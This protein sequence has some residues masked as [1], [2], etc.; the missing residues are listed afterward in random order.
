MKKILV[1]GA[2]ALALSGCA[3]QQPEAPFTLT[4][5]HINDTHSH[6]DP[7]DVPLTLD[8]RRVYTRLG[9][10][11]RL[12]SQA[13]S[14]REQATLADQPLLFVHGGGA[15]QGSGYFQLNQGAMNA[16]LLGRL[17]L[18]AM[19][20]GDPEFALDN[21]RLAVFIDSVGVPVLAA[22]LNTEREPV[23]QGA[24]NLYPYVLYAFDGNDKER[25]AS[26]EDAGRDPV[27]AVFGLVPEALGEL[28]ANTGGLRFEHEVETAQ[29][30]VDALR[31]Q[32]VKHIVA[33][34]HLGLERDQR[35]ASRV[36]G[37]DLIVG[38]RSESLLG[39]FAS[40]GL[41]KQPPY[42]Q[43]VT[44]PDGRAKTCV[45]QA[46]HFGQAM[47]RVSVTFSRDGRVTRCEGGNTLLAD[48]EFYRDV[49]RADSHRLSAAEQQRLNEVVA[50]DPRITVV[51]EDAELRRH[52]DEQYQPALNAAYGTV[53]GHV[54]ATLS[55][56]L[57]ERDGSQSELAPL[58]AASQLYWVNTP[59]VR[60]VTGRRADLAL[61][62]ASAVGTALE[63]GELK[64]GKVRQ[65]LLPGATPLSLVSVTG[66]DLA[67]LLLETING[68]LADDLR[69]AAFPYTAGL[70]YQF[71]ETRKGAGFLRTLE[72]RQG[73]QWVR[74]DP[75]ASYT[76]VMN[77]DQASGKDGWHTLYQT[78]Q[79]LT[80]RIDLARV[81][82]R[83]TAFPVARL[84]KGQDGT[85][86]HYINQ[87]LN[88]GAG[89]V[90][91]DTEVEAFIDYVQERRPLLSPLADTGITLNR[92]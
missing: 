36:N 59:E 5:A 44:N 8:G 51:A 55:H 58:V 20:L 12:L 40:L 74:V 54:P 82:G 48:G 30:T 80:D 9:G 2:L 49:R 29:R 16:D 26:M 7:S 46:G 76:V 1:A 81:N 87:P 83:L 68:A 85:Q 52:I 57:P 39:D 78:Q 53:I 35:L 33:L 23:L 88:C 65:E 6:F 11:P 41:G 10:F 71:D 45:V 17:G 47:G 69:A 27:V 64:Q 63:P 56:G 28:G 79:V 15:W 3:S 62:A 70:R 84:S 73:A 19:V 86:V 34:T 24:A 43:Q 4:L 32:G 66:R 89:G 38:G 25:L 14:L 18:D 60:A 31:A 90:R 42:A 92:W 13:N 50:A 22:N 61:V 37:I 75:N 77:A 72:V 21:R 67:G 91:C